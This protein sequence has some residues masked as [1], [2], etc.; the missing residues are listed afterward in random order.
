MP[1][2]GSCHSLTT[3]QQGEYLQQECATI[4]KGHRHHVGKKKQRN[5]KPSRQ[6]SS[7]IFTCQN[8]MSCHVMV[9]S[10]LDNIGTHP[11][12][13][14]SETQPPTSLPSLDHPPTNHLPQSP[15]PQGFTS[16][17]VWYQSR[18]LPLPQHQ[19][20]TPAIQTRP[21]KQKLAEAAGK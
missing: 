17:K 14:P 21:P 12:L 16:S 7:T 4:S 8:S 11:I 10:K 19:S 9:V 15:Y 5:A 1:C 3:E 20:S 13:P 2:R 6:P 18:R